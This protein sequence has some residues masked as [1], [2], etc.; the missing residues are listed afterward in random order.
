MHQNEKKTLLGVRRKMDMMQK[1]NISS[2]TLTTYC[3][4]LL[5]KKK[6]TAVIQQLS[7]DEVNSSE[8]LTE[9]TESKLSS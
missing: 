3:R 4:Y 6:L 1:L 2:K 5:K 7:S 8:K 9:A